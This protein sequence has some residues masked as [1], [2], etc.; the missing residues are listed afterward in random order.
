[1]YNLF[2]V[3][4][5]QTV[6]DGLTNCIDWQNHNVQVCGYA[7]DG[8]TAYD[9]IIRLKP[10][11]V[12]TD[13]RMPGITGLDLIDRVNAV[14]SDIKFIVFSGYSEF[15]HAKHA[16][17]SN[18]VDYLVKPVP[19][20]E[21]V[22]SV[23]KAIDLKK[24]DKFHLKLVEDSLLQSNEIQEKYYYD[25][26]LQN[27]PD[28]LKF[29]EDKMCIIAVFRIKN[30]SEL[31]DEFEQIYRHI[32]GETKLGGSIGYHLLKMPGEYVAIINCR[33][34]DSD[35]LPLI[36]KD[37]I[38]DNRDWFPVESIDEVYFGIS[39]I[40]SFRGIS[41][42]Y[43]EALA[44][45][46]YSEYLSLPVTFYKEV[47]YN[48][49]DLNIAQW[50]QAIDM[51]LTRRNMD[52]ISA[53]LDQIF[54]YCMDMH[55]SPIIVK[56][57]DLD[58]VYHSIEM[59]EHDLKL[60]T[61]QIW[62]D[63]DNFIKEVEKLVSLEDSK[64]YLNNF[65]RKI[66]EFISRKS[67]GLKVKTINKLKEYI[68]NNLSKP[69]TLD[70][71]ADVVRKSSGYVSMVFKNETGSTITQYITDKKISHAKE[72]LTK[73]DCKISEIAHEI[74]FGEERYFYQIFKKETGLTAGDYR[75]LHLLD[76]SDENISIK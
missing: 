9:S 40:A 37:Q 64:H 31:N 19:I 75:K 27:K 56:K 15:E 55:I 63:S 7:S 13:I 10:D 29:S 57:L 43:H 51:H 58:L 38:I 73:S 70:E 18:A 17:R 2:I 26:I 5:E 45:V 20:E 11:I 44:A 24:Q 6:I 23:T 53:I 21:L 62:G 60:S 42:A 66:I 35:L 69:I 68:K 14:C 22:K 25:A 54:D 30:A 34:S 72:L 48:E 46:G 71:L 12:I 8:N 16:L 67:I 33:E 28:I 76:S 1:M 50:N 32:K 49:V 41:A 36:V 52:A 65:Y 59:S 4:D 39:N 61:K 74:G 47:K 3:D